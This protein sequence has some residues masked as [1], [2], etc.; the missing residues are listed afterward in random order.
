MKRSIAL[1]AV[2]VLSFNICVCQATEPPQNG[3]MFDSN[4]VN[5]VQDPLPNAYLFE[6][7]NDMF[8]L[9]WNILG[10]DLSHWSLK[11]IPGTL[12]I[13]T[14]DGSFT[15]YRTDYKNIFLINF[16]VVQS[17]DFQLTTCV[18]NFNPYGFWNQAGLILWIDKDNNFKFV[19]EYG[20]G[21]PPNNAPKLLFT[22]AV[23]TNAYV[24]HGWFE[25][26]QYP[27]NMW[28]R[29]IKRGGFYEL[30]SSTDGQSFNP[31]KV[32]LPARLTA[33]NTVPCLSAPLQYIGVFADNG[34]AYGA[35]QVDA[36]FDFFEFKVLPKKQ[37]TP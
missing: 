13:T 32:I 14:Q 17:A 16:P 35:P 3:P 19:Y 20:E 8:F 33:D 4:D 9:N 30:F 12:T 15:R 36:S 27:Q 2:G 31:A 6:D 26:E 24:V 11:K 34:T 7:F 22:A 28:L 18:T 21:P 25:A 10:N 5:Q 1:L 29:I 23:E 37:E